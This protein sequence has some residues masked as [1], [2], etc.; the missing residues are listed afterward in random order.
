ME[1][2][3]KAGQLILSL[4]I[5]IVLH[6]FGHYLPA[7]WFKTRVEKFYLF[8]DYKFALFKKKIKE[9][10]W[11]IGWIPLG[12][13]VKISGMIDESMDTEQM[14][15]EPQPYEFRTKKAWQRLI[16]MIGGIVVNFVVGIIIYC[17]VLFTWG[18]D[19]YKMEDLKNGF[20]P[21]ETMKKYGF[22]DGD[23]IIDV[24]G[25]VPLDILDV[26]TMIMLRGGH[27][28]N[29]QHADGT[30]EKITLSEDVEWDLFQSEGMIAFSPRVYTVVGDLDTT[31]NA[32]KAGIMKGD[33]IVAI[34]SVPTIYFDEF[35]TEIKKHKSEKVTISLYRNQQPLS[36]EVSTDT[37]GRIGIGP[38]RLDSI[39]ALR[40]KDYSFAE[41]IPAGFSKAFTVLGDY[42]AQMKF[43][44]TKKGAS[45]IGGFGTFGSLFSPTWD[46]HSFWLMTAF[47]SIVLAFMNF[48]PI[49]ALDG[50]HI[51]FLLY[52]MI[53]GRKPGD[54]FME[55]AQMVGI[56]LLLGLLIYANGND[57]YKL[58]TGQ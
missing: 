21:S 1:F 56:I 47:I 10:E 22:K 27:I 51:M 44:F 36:I 35:K 24:D 52:E 38:E 31:M 33:S 39:Y 48:L 46:W 28:V 11:G 41:S 16:I 19:Y 55:Y 37:S 54:K 26:N 23:K 8:F 6:E 30:S 53:T 2:L 17:M 32:V 29:V 9:T 5:L 49:P 58:F 42:V 12:G 13:Y 40:H 3:I 4:S 7:R 34:N 25:E 18:E 45:N 14:K 15:K 43:L 57:L 50:G 20:T